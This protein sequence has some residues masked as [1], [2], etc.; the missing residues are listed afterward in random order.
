M[1]NYQCDIILTA[2]VST[3]YTALTT[4]S[5]IRGWWTASCDAGT[6]VGE[7]ITI[8]F[9]TTFKL[10]CIEKLRP[11][12]EVRWRVIDAELDVPGLTRT[13]EWIG[14]T[15][16]FQLE[17]QSASVTRLQVEHIGL[18]QQVECYE[19][20][21]QGWIQFLGSLKSYVETG[22]GAPYGDPVA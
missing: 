4:Q 17:P 22:T 9:G 21:S 15:I 11:E 5:G 20:C 6:A 19:L 16:V 7:H 14:T 3:V 12:A 13:K 10:M 8:R 1:K 18:T 2:P